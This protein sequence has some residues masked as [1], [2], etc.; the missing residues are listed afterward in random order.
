MG[1]QP[2][3]TGGGLAVRVGSELSCGAVAGAAMSS[4]LEGTQMVPNKDGA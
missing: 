1:L 3:A 4:S 2:A